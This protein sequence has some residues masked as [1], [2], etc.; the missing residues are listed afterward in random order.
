VFAI[1]DEY[2]VKIFMTLLLLDLEDLFFGF[3]AQLKY[4]LD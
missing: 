3:A 1:A 2:V 4:R